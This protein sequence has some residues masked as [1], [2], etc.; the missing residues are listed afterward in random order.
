MNIVY[1]YKNLIIMQTTLS[2]LNAVN[3]R[4]PRGWKVAVWCDANM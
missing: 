2:A 1:T 3:S 4:P